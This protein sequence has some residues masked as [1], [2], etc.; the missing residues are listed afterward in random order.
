MRDKI[1]YETLEKEIGTLSISLSK[2]KPLKWTL[3][4]SQ[5][6]F[7]RGGLQQ[8]TRKERANMSRTGAY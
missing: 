8:A 7:G 3:T 4:T 1:K 6:D 5:H 2:I